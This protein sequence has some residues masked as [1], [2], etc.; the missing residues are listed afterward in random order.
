MVQFASRMAN[1]KPSTIREILHLTRKPHVTSFA[2]GLPAPN[3]FPLARL[4]DVAGQVWGD[5]AN[6]QYSITEGE[7]GLR[8]AIASRSVGHPSADEILVVS[9]SQQALDLVGKLMI[10]PGDSVIVESPTYMGALRAFDVYEPEYVTVA[11]DAQG[12]DPAGVEAALKGGARLLYLNPNFSNPTGR[13]MSSERRKEIVALVA[14]FD[15]LIYEDDPYGQLRFA[16]TDLDPMISMD[17]QHVLYAGSFSKV[18]VPGFRLGW[19]QGPVELIEPLTMIKQASDLHTSTT[20]QAI[21]AAAI[22]DGFLEEHLAE[23]RTYY[24]SQRDVMLGAL[25][26]HFPSDA[27]WTVPEG[28]MFIWATLAEGIDTTQL[29]GEAVDAGV[30]FVPGQPFHADGR[31]ANTMRLS[32]SVATPKAI[33]WGIEQLGLVIRNFAAR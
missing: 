21:A 25:D 24:R 3:L 15:G 26:R 13:T 5:P 8:N 1:V 17:S 16:G 10:N 33:E 31:G 19:I 18:L 4:R 29:L 30:A 14:A 32:Y 27:Q 9:G 2:G 20:T 7:L 12:I 23:V 6:V 28:G 11:S 22:G